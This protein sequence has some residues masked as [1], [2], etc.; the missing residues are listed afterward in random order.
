MTGIPTDTAFTR[1]FG[2]EVPIIQ[3]PMGMAAGPKLVAAA[4][5]GGLQR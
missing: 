5:R 2:L 4:A 1:A 3:A